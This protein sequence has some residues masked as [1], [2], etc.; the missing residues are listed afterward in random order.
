MR[1]RDVE[2]ELDPPPG[3][4][5]PLPERAKTLRDDRE[6]LR[7]MAPVVRALHDAAG[8]PNAY[9]V[10]ISADGDGVGE[11]ID[12]HA[13]T[14]DAHRAL[15]QL[16]T[17]HAGDAVDLI[18]RGD[19]NGE[20]IY[21]GGEDLLA[22]L[23][24][25][26]A[27]DVVIELA[28]KYTDRWKNH[29]HQ[30]DDSQSA[31]NVQTLSVGIAIA[32]C[33]DAFDVVLQA[34]RD[35]ERAAKEARRSDL[36]RGR[37]QTLRDDGTSPGGYCTVHWMPRQGADVRLTGPQSMLKRMLSF[38]RLHRDDQVSDAIGYRLLRLSAAY[39]GWASV[40]RRHD[41]LRSALPLELARQLL[42]RSATAEA[43][44]QIA[45]ALESID[46]DRLHDADVTLRRLGHELVLSRR[47]A[48]A[49]R[50]AEPS[51]DET[52]TT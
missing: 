46:F 23:P 12:R 28:Q 19:N 30:T 45:A 35:G 42:R 25:D 20:A 8:V 14:I 22:L 52:E 37:R 7:L 9:Y 31:R 1:V 41:D 11:L 33:L 47:I 36:E 16:L 18:R 26:R 44:V 40:D 29:T 32:H 3:Q 10:V 17:A 48:H 43:K 15:S 38:A 21:A 24:L 5:G 51:L 49:M 27:F 2:A 50:Q 34:A 13:E 4:P 39:D 6:K